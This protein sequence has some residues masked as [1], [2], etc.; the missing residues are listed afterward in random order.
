M[1]EGVLE[2]EAKVEGGLTITTPKVSVG[3]SNL[4]LAVEE[5]SQVYI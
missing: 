3:L 2:Q 1:G 4:T 5:G